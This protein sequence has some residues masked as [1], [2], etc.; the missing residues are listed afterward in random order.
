MQFTKQELIELLEK[1]KKATP[2]PWYSIGDTGKSDFRS[3]D[4]DDGWGYGVYTVSPD[5]E[6]PGWTTNGSES[7]G[8][9]EKNANF[10]AASHPAVVQSLIESVIGL[11]EALQ[12]YDEW[13]WVDGKYSSDYKEW[14]SEY[15][16][17]ALEKYGVK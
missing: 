11:S 14:P 13:R 7:H 9:D 2:G 15:A 16:D 1:A 8:I 6:R 17:E 4:W 5:P 10:I 12:Y 3:D